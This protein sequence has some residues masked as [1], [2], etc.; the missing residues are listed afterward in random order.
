MY[1]LVGS[2][3]PARRIRI[4]LI[5]KVFGWCGVVGV[6]VVGAVSVFCWC[7]ENWCVKAKMERILNRASWSALEASQSACLKNLVI[8]LRLKLFFST[9][10]HFLKSF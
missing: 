10:S 5:L 9:T 1:C 7:S 8:F 6:F 2:Q 3:N 4:M